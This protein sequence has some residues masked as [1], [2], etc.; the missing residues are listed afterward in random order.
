MICASVQR[1][2]DAGR[3]DGQVVRL[4]LN[5]WPPGFAALTG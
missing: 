5:P 2:S 4:H 3:L 1:G